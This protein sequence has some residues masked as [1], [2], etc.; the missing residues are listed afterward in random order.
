MIDGVPA[1]RMSVVI[2]SIGH[3]TRS[4]KS[5]PNVTTVLMHPPSPNWRIE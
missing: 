2:P 3:R 1:G 5:D 4:S